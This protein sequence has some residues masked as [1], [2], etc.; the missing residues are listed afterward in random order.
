MYLFSSLLLSQFSQLYMYGSMTRT[1]SHVKQGT[2]G[3]D[4]MTR[5]GSHV[6]QGTRGAGRYFAIMLAYTHCRQ[7]ILDIMTMS[8]IISA[9][10]SE[11]PS[12]PSHQHMPE[13][14]FSY[15]ILWSLLRSGS[16]RERGY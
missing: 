2:T 9:Q 8:V 7:V 5:T 14:V 12:R 11:A 10:V 15:A 6:E 13:R 4:S 1:G 3:A 16:S